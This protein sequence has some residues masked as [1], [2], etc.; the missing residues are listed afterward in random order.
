MRDQEH[1]E[2]KRIAEEDRRKVFDGMAVWK[3]GMA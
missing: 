2:K 1:A 3:P